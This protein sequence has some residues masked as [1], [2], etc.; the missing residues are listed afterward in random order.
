MATKKERIPLWV[1]IV[2]PLI[3]ILIM[4]CV[5]WVVAKGAAEEESDELGTWEEGLGQ[6][7]TVGAGIDAAQEFGRFIQSIFGG[8]A[9]E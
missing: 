5:A 9:T 2:F 8:Q 6:L 3:A 7:G 1:W 4:L